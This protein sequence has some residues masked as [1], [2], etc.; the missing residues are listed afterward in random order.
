MSFIAGYLLGLG[1]GQGGTSS[2]PRIEKLI[3]LPEVYRFD[4]AD[5]W[6][7]R[8]KISADIDD[9]CLMKF[10]TTTHQPN[11][12]AN[13]YAA[14][15]CTYLNDDF[16]FSIST[17]FVPKFDEDFAGTYTDESGQIV[18]VPNQIVTYSDFSAVSGEMTVGNYE[19][20]ILRLSVDLKGTQT[21]VTYG[22]NEQGE[23]VPGEPYVNTNFS[24]SA[25]M[26]FFYSYD[27]NYIV[28]GSTDDLHDYLLSL[29]YACTKLM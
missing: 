11:K 7:V 18:F 26:T 8:V 19:Y 4:I 29:Y 9:S 2:D 3:A 20:A 25:R 12:Y 6:N 14:Y 10:N 1:Q 16:K 22:L 24:T 21:S 13:Y 15:F 17:F 28:N 27:Y 5:G 23:W